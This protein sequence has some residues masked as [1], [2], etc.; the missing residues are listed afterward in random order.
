MMRAA[1]FAAQLGFTPAPEVVAAMRGMADRISIIS[2][3]GCAM[4]FRS[5]C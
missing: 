2:A 1:R 5:C 3:D 4:S